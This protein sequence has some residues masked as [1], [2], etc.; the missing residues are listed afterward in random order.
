LFF[1]RSSK[2]VT[3]EDRGIMGMNRVVLDLPQIFLHGPFYELISAAFSL[4][5]LKAF[6]VGLEAWL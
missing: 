3:M 6:S 4:D 1:Q 2:L 5:L